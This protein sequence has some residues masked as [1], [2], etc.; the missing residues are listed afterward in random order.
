MPANT[1]RGYT[2][3]FYTDPADFPAQIAA[4]LLL[5]DVENI[6]DERSGYRDRIAF[7][8]HEFGIVCLCDPADCFCVA[9]AFHLRVPW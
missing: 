5:I 2:Y 7:G 4:E 8:Q 1:P 9:W 6:D 3:P